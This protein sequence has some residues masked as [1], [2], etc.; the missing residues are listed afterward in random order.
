[1]EETVGLKTTSVTGPSRIK[2][3][4]TLLLLHFVFM[5]AKAVC[6]PWNAF[7][8]CL[9]CKTWGAVVLKC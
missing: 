5:S 3:L 7:I 6:L 9:L 4:A 2:F 8:I 1:M